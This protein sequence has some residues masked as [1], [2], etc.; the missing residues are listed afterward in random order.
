MTTVL[1]MV[2]VAAYIWAVIMIAMVTIHNIN[3]Y[4]G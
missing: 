2:F 4:G 1:K 3:L